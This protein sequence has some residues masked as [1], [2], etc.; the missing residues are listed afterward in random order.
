MSFPTVRTTIRTVALTTTLLIAGATLLASSAGAQEETGD[1]SAEKVTFVVGTTDDIS[2][3]NPFAATTTSTDYEMLF[4]TYDMLQNYDPAT[5]A[6]APGVAESYELSEDGLTYTFKITPGQTWSDGKP[7]TAHDVAFTYNFIMDNEGTGAFK[8]YLGDPE[9]FTAP[10]DETFIWKL[11]EP[12]N[13]PSAIPYIPILPEHVWA[14]FDGKSSSDIKGYDSMPQIG[15]GPFE[16]TEWERGQVI[17]FAPNPE[18]I[19][20]APHIDELIFRIFENQEAMVTALKAG[21]IDAMNN[22]TPD[23]FD[24]LQ[25]EPGITTFE[26]TAVQEYNLALN[27]TP[28]SEDWIGTEPDWHKGDVSTGS[29]ALM[30]VRVRRAIAMA[31][32]KQALVDNVLG[33]HAQVGDSFIFPHYSWYSPPPAEFSYPHDMNKAKALMEE[34]GFT[35]SDGDGVREEADGSPMEFDLLVLANNEYSNQSGK[36]VK[37]WLDE[38]GWKVNLMPVAGGKI[39]SLWYKSDYDGYIWY[40]GV[41]PDPNFML[42]IF[43]AGQCLEWSDTCWSDPEYEKLYLKQLAE[44]DVDKRHEIVTEMQN[45]FYEQVPEQFLFYLKD[46][47]AVR[48]DKWEGFVNIPEPN[49]GY[50]YSWGPASYINVQPIAGGEVSTSGESGGG[51][52]F[53]YIGIAAVVLVV[54]GLMLRARGRKAEDDA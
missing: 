21:E 36:F 11:K 4:L 48:T 51:S 46:L 37:E 23:L 22:L 34:A 10:D 19:G 27:L 3:A 16:L 31:M 14:P 43:T 2:T 17:R 29:P 28:S 44:T 45:I 15:S 39:T 9:S 25:G 40:W 33:G 47:Q 41:E 54:V 24:S 7:V 50:I 5:L 53:L 52:A 6:A 12:S 1:A 42:S 35:D 13:A 8:I 20:G 49:G 30:D 38:L 26:T 32:D 18:Y